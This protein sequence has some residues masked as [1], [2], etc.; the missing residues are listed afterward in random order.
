MHG[1]RKLFAAVAMA[2]LALA[3]CKK[4]KDASTEAAGAAENSAAT[5]EQK[6]ANQKP[7]EEAKAPEGC[8]SDFSQAIKVDYTLTR[9]C[10]PYTLAD[11]RTL[12]V[13]GWYLTIEPGVEV[14]FGENAHLEVGYNQKGRLV[15]QGTE[16]APITFTSAKRKEPGYW[17]G[18]RL[19]DNAGG[20][21]IDHAVLEYGG[22]TD[23]AALVAN[24]PD[25]KLN[26]IKFVGIAGR[27][28]K[29]EQGLTEWRDVHV[30]DGR[31]IPGDGDHV[32]AIERGGWMQLR[33]ARFR[34]MPCPRKPRGSPARRWR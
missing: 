1:T 5:A 34:R 2:S 16:E 18:I 3:G 4:D 21:V 31:R 19:N 13:D 23:R 10:S 24:G 7:A 28:V 17:G 14:R 22:T 11:G 20:S 27:A 9:K 15:A 8:N 25:I 30:V 32:T 6:P 33:P 26:H 12:T 29:S